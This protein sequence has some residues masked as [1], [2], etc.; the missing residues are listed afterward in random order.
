MDPAGDCVR[1]DDRTGDCPADLVAKLRFFRHITSVAHLCVDQPGI[2]VCFQLM[3]RQ[4]MS[5]VEISREARVEHLGG[6]YEG[7]NVECLLRSRAG[8]AAVGVWGII[9]RIRY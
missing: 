5:F 2:P 3:F 4:E 1:L 6:I 9:R 7:E 8:L